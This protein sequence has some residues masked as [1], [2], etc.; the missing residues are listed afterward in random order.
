[1]PTP[2]LLPEV[3][4]VRVVRIA[5]FDGLSVLVMGGAFALINAMD[6]NTALATVGLA[7]AGAGAV[8]L[9]GVGQ[10][11]SGDARGLRWLLA[12]QP[13]LLLA[14]LAYCALRLWFI[15]LPPLPEMLRNLVE[16][17]AQQLGMSVEAYQHFINRLTMILVAIASVG[18]QGGMFIYYWRRRAVI[19]RALAAAE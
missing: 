19:Q 2:P 1:M 17:S 10:L 15:P 7:A 18:V 14:V 4:L 9:H 8:E 5:R 16:L 12:S 13:F 3:V 6:H 11:E